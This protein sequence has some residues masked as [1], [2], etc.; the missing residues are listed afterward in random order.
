MLGYPSPGEY[1]L[2]FAIVF[3]AGVAT[4]ICITKFTEKVRRVTRGHA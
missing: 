2:V 4:T 1:L 3:L